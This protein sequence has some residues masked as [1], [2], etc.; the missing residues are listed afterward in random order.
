MAEA[1]L[2]APTRP[3]PHALSDRDGLAFFQA[4]LARFFRGGFLL[5]VVQ[6]ALN[7]VIVAFAGHHQ[8]TNHLFGAYDSLYEWGVPSLATLACLG[9]WRLLLGRGRTART[10]GA[11]D[12]CG[13]V[14]ICL[15]LAVAHVNVPPWLRPDM[16]VIGLIALVLAA[17]PVVVPST[18][19]HPR[20]R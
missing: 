20:D 9:L 15:L 1:V 10:L 17:R 7:A 13:T 19:R 18:A 8:A 14:G 11:I 5:G 12:A 4:R 3:S 16:F 6:L 2:R